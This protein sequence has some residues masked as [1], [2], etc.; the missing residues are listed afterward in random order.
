MTQLNTFLVVASVDISP[1]PLS[2]PIS[3][4]RLG[5]LGATDNLPF[6]GWKNI[7]QTMTETDRKSFISAGLRDV[8]RDKSLYSW[9]IRSL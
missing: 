1:P 7:S 5:W 2:R 8:G 6:M 4:E 3:H 9:L